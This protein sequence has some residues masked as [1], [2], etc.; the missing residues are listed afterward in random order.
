MKRLISF[1][2]VFVLFL[3]L[4]SCSKDNA[5]PSASLVTAPEAD[6]TEDTSSGGVY[7][8]AFVGSSGVVK[9]TL[10]KGKFEVMITLD[11]VSKVLTT[12]ALA[13]WTTGQA[14]NNIDFTNGDW[15]ATFSVS[16]NGG[17]PT[18][19]IVIPGHTINVAL[20]K[21]ISTKQVKAYEGTYEGSDSGTFNFVIKG[22]QLL[23]VIRNSDG[24]MDGF[25]GTVSGNTITIQGAGAVG[26]IN[27]NSVSGTWQDL[28]NAD[29]KGTWKGK[30]TL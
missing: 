11:G 17:S 24:G 8:G 26:T 27:G 14:L 10:Q 23:G 4:L 2:T 16:A 28:Q 15:K 19:I 29:N 3:L 7:K 6:A 18:L 9:I 20:V 1:S 5:D 12:T 13:N 22:E 30:R 25:Y 21:E